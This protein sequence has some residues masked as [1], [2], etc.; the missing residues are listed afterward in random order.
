MQNTHADIIQVIHDYM[1]DSGTAWRIGEQ[2]V[3]VRDA[4]EEVEISL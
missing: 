1:S 3:F 2:A 4:D